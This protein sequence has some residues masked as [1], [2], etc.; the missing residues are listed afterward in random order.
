[1]CTRWIWVGP[2]IVVASVWYVIVWGSKIGL[3]CLV[4][5]GSTAL[6][7][8]HPYWPA[9]VHSKVWDC[10]RRYDLGALKFDVTAK[11]SCV[12]NQHWA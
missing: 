7:P 8:A 5:I 10:W 9:F 11:S 2:V 6:L 12:C 1:M 3:T 4:L